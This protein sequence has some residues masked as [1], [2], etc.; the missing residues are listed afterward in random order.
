MIAL[1]LGCLPRTFDVAGILSSA[2]PAA[3]P[4]ERIE[5]AP[6]LLLLALDPVVPAQLLRSQERLVAAE[7][8]GDA[9][10]QHRQPDDGPGHGQKP[11][12][13]PARLERRTDLTLIDLVEPA[14]LHGLLNQ[15]DAR[16][17]RHTDD[18]AGSER[19]HADLQLV[20]PQRPGDRRSRREEG[21]HDQ[22]PD[23]DHDQRGDYYR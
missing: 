18:E 12:E 15:R 9:R 23:H 11:L 7:H 13:V 3:F 6:E 4:G 19:Q 14:T 20:A 17:G 21:E 5:G 10:G 1:L 16:Q 8:A 22:D 2:T